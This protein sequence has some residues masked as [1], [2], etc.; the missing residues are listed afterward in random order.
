MKPLND[1]EAAAYIGVKPQTMRTWRYRNIGPKFYRVSRSVVRYHKEDLDKF[2]ADRMV[3]PEQP[4][5]EG[6]K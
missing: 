1:I 2:L 3:E 4:D 5:L 6:A